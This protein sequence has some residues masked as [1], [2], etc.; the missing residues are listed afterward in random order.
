MGLDLYLFSK[1]KDQSI[2]AAYYT[3]EELAY[4]R[5]TWSLYYFFKEDSEEVEDFVFKIPEYR[6]DH[7][8]DVTRALWEMYGGLDHINYLLRW[9]YNNYE[10][11]DDMTDEDLKNW[12][13]LSC[14]YDDWTDISPQL[15]E[16]WELHAVIRWYEADAEVKAAFARG[17]DVLMLASY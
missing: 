16:D 11:S 3:G 1:K 10:D 6:W 12:R 2:E 9:A 15:G 7:F 14:L 17:E 13:E 8:I 5:K 4:G